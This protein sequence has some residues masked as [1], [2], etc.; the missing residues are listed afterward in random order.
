MQEEC[1]W[2]HD[3]GGRSLLLQSEHDLVSRARR[4]HGYRAMPA[5]L[6]GA[7]QVTAHD[8]LHLRVPL[9]DL[10]QRL[11]PFETQAV[12]VGDA[13]MERSVVHE[14][15]RG[16]RRCL[17][18]PGG[19]PGQ[20]LLAHEPTALANHERVQADQAEWILLERVVEKRP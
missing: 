18:E 14:D 13:G 7:M 1:G 4:G 3:E 9:D 17:L 20:A 12:H 11:R 10:A 8:T 19:E 16:A 2:F 5:H 6:D 15:H